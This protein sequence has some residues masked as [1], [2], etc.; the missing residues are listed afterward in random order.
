MNGG[1]KPRMIS[2][3][4]RIYYSIHYDC[5]VAR[6]SGY[7]ER[8][9]EHWTEVETGRGYRDRRN[10]ALQRIMASIEAGD[11]PGELVE[12]GQEE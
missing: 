6:L 2:W 4:E 7:D 12:K 10:D 11:L 3:T 5:E 8:H 9:Q 1:L